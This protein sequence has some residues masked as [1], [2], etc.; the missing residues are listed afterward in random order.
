MH[1]FKLY[2]LRSCV[3]SIMG[4]VVMNLLSGDNLEPKSKDLRDQCL[5]HLEDHIHDIH[6][7]IRS[8]VSGR[9]LFLLFHT[10]CLQWQIQRKNF[11]SWVN[12]FYECRRRKLSVNGNKSKIMKFTRWEV[13]RKVMKWDG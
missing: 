5:E 6:A 11:V 13:N 4:S 3:L 9:T 1:F 8:K 2:S 12:S 10:S 7:L